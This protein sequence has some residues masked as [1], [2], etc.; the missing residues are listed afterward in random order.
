MKL[1]A[2]RSGPV[3]YPE[4]TILS[5][6][7]ALELGADMVEIDVRNEWVGKSLIELNLRKKYSINI[8]AIRKGD[9]V[10]IDINPQMPLDADMELIILASTDSINKLNK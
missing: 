6:R 3:D 1:I 7:Q 8:V 2:H 10:S 4:Q 9:S 5:A